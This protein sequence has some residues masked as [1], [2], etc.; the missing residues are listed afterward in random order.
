MLASCIVSLTAH[1]CRSL[2]VRHAAVAARFAAIRCKH[3]I[4]TRL[5][6]HIADFPVIR[7]PAFA[8][9]ALIRSCGECF[10]AS[11]L[12]FPKQPPNSVK[13]HLTGTAL[14]LH[15][16]PKQKPRTFPTLVFEH[17]ANA[18]LLCTCGK[19][20]A[21]MLLKPQKRSFPNGL[22]GPT[23]TAFSLHIT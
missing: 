19:F 21:A 16:G 14:S 23:Y 20:P 17:I 10:D 18:A 1:S 4:W 3:K 2:S 7:F 12:T 9:A 22:S 5:N 8:G 13:S 15:A 6:S 11:R